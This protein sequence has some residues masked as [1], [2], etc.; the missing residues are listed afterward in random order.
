MYEYCVD[1]KV[2]PLSLTD[3]EVMAIISGEVRRRCPGAAQLN[4]A[5]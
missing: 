2:V 1:N 3:D 4:E 5:Q